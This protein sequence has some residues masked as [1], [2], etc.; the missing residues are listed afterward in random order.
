[1]TLSFTVPIPDVPGKICMTQRNNATYVRYQVSRIY[2][3][4][5][6]FNVPVFKIIG[7]KVGDNSMI[8][9]ENYLKFFGDLELPQIKNNSDK[10]SCLRIGSFL[11]IRSIMKEYDLP[12]LLEKYFGPENSRMLQDLAAYLI[13]TENDSTQ[14]FSEYAYNHP[15]FAEEC[16]HYKTIDIQKFFTSISD[17]QK[18]GFLNE[19]DARNSHKKPI[20]VSYDSLNS[21]CQ[22]LNTALEDP[23]DPQR[24]DILFEYATAYDADN[25]EPL[26]FG[27]Y[28]AGLLNPQHLQLIKEKALNY[29]YKKIGFVFEEGC[30][31]E[32]LP[33]IDSCGY[34]FIL[35]A[36]RISSLGREIISENTGKFEN[37]KNSDIPQ[38]QAHGITVKRPL[39]D[40]GTADRYFHIYYSSEKASSDRKQEEARIRRMASY[41]NYMKGHNIP[42]SNDCKK[43]FEL[44]MDN[45]EGILLQYRK[46]EEAIK[47]DLALCGYYLIITS[48]KMS[49]RNALELYLNREAS[50][51]IFQCNK[52]YFNN[53]AGIQTDDIADSKKLV[54]FIALIVRCGIYSHLKHNTVPFDNTPD[55]GIVISAIREL[56]RIEM[57]YQ[58]DKK[59]RIDHS[60]TSA[61]REILYAFGMDNNMIR[62]DINGLSDLL[63]KHSDSISQ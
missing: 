2:Y 50:K 36:S 53:N 42:I 46:N 10:C 54:E 38:Y 52:S 16:D 23:G 56:E 24:S 17:E 40:L 25:K 26:F 11:V 12:A 1:M 4:E 34:D 44:E 33:H 60:I 49:A 41:L 29:G 5:K 47:N 28:P 55:S 57:V 59:Y 63:A 27:K 20:Y 48:D 14:Y 43:Y 15:L 9:N 6:K 35:P 51:K 30:R 3:P 31:E 13:V 62:N 58:A 61:Q 32:D 19:W 7:R 37:D 39:S 22:I 45:S 18:E 21:N 8:P